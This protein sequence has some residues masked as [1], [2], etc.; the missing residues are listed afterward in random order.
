[1]FS[2]WILLSLLGLAL[3]QWGARPESP[4]ANV[5]PGE[6]QY[7]FTVTAG[8]MRDS[9]RTDEVNALVRELQAD[10]KAIQEENKDLKKQIESIRNDY[11]SMVAGV[12]TLEAETASWRSIIEWPQIEM[13]FQPDNLSMI[14][15][16][17]PTFDDCQKAWNHGGKA[18]IYLLKPPEALVPF[19]SY[20]DKEGWTVI[21]RRFDGTVD[22]YRPWD[23]YSRG[24]GQL[25]G[26]FWLG[27]E[28]MHLLTAVQ[29]YEL[30]V[31]ALGWN[32]KLYHTAYE[33][34]QVLDE[35]K[36]YKLLIGNM[37][38]GNTEDV[39]SSVNGTGF[40]TWD[41]DNDEWYS[42]NCAEYYR[43][44]FWLPNCG[45]DP[46]RRWCETRGCMTWGDK[47]VKK[48]MFKMRQ[49]GGG[50]PPRAGEGRRQ[51]AKPYPDPPYPS[52]PEYP[53][54]PEYPPQ[55]PQPQYPPQP[56]H[57]PPAQPEYPQPPPPPE[58]PQ[59]P[60]PEYP[61][62]PEYPDPNEDEYK[63]DDYYD[64]NYDSDGDSSAYGKK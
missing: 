15:M 13:P 33:N 23:D 19:F 5:R 50:A 46:N 49:M 24:F 6:C 62:P 31:E 55:P 48:T 61:R 18:G 37:T 28:N 20:C 17:E 12:K 44:G 47:V 43:G 52:V 41:R 22:F 1:M 21:Q 2:S 45:S 53:Y 60:P 64:G 29:P 51:T 38:K 34:F 11:E 39:M 16:K 10:N 56:G 40:T 9:C 59:P 54:Q 27:L 63:Y 35:L 4:P 14:I 25:S 30:R 57:P 26:E 42:A 3:G 7:T 36:E 32:G 58:Y 8:A